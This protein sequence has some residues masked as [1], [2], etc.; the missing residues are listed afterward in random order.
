M[1]NLTKMRSK[2]K[3]LMNQ[4]KDDGNWNLFRVHTGLQLAYKV[5][6]NSVYGRFIL[7]AK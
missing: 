2:H 3:K 5:C 4:A 6:A 7:L 1:A